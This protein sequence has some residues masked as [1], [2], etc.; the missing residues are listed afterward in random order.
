M[1]ANAPFLRF[2][3]Q[4]MHCSNCARQVQEA[5]ERQDGVGHVETLLEQ[6]EVRIHSSFLQGKNPLELSSLGP[7]GP[8]ARP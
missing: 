3:V 5:F 1:Q 2:R 7:E 8:R 6:R 4:S